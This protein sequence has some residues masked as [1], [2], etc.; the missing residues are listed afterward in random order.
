[1]VKTEVIEELQA[2]F[3]TITAQSCKYCG[4]A[5][6][7][8][9]VGAYSAYVPDCECLSKKQMEETEQKERISKFKNLSKRYK[10]ANFPYDTRG[11]RFKKL[12]SEHV[13]QARKFINGFK[14]RQ[15]QG[16]MLIGNV[17][18]GKT[19][20]A[21]CIGKE[22][23]LRGYK[24]KFL[25]FSNAIRLIQSSYGKE[26]PLSF[27]EQVDELAKYDLLIFDDFGRETYKDRT[28]T[29]VADL[30][31]HLYTQKT[32]VIITSNPEMIAK[33]KKIPDFNAMLDRFAEMTETIFF[34]KASYRRKI[35][36]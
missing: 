15:R 34:T 17:G 3:I 14:P 2:T 7:L 8:L 36:N 4:K 35:D 13:I 29:D 21:V 22:L 33:I 26:N 16:L 5:H 30:I 32:N 20:F 1:M 25:G 24:V 6:K 9:T 23:L 11:K 27:T 18:N 31:N 12:K 10:I 19:T 28:L